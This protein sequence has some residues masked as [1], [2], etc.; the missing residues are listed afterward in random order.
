MELSL[1]YYRPKLF[2][3]GVLLTASLV[4][5]AVHGAIWILGQDS[6]WSGWLGGISTATV[7]MLLL[8]I[9]DRYLWKYWPLKFLV[10]VPNVSGM[11]RGVVRFEREGIKQTKSVEAVITQTATRLVVRCRFFYTD[12]ADPQETHSTCTDCHIVERGGYHRL[13]MAYLNEGVRITNEMGPHEG[14]AQ[15]HIEPDRSRLIGP[16]FT[17]RLSKGEMELNRIID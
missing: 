14:F 2:I 13:D 6:M 12:R 11:Y 1:R 16:Y 10:T 8:G 4:N 3:A 17:G 9:Y 15:L 5:T 7:V